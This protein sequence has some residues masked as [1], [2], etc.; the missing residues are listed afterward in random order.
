MSKFLKAFIVGIIIISFFIASIYLIKGDLIFHTDIARDFLLLGEI[1]TKKIVLIG[2][3]A[4]GLNGLF[5]GPLWLYLNYPAYLLG[6]G[7]PVIVGWWWLI[8]T[9]SFLIST[10][11]LVKKLFNSN[12]AYLSLLLISNL[13]IPAAKG[14]FNPYGAMFVFPIFFYFVIQYAKSMSVKYLVILLFLCGLLIQFQLAFGLPI[15][16]L[17]IFYTIYLIFKNKKYLHLLSFLILLIP[18]STFILFDFRHDFSQFHA[19]FDYFTGKIKYEKVSMLTMLSSRLDVIFFSMIELGWLNKLNAL[20]LV[21]VSYNILK[22][23]QKSDSTSKILSIF[24]YYFL[25]FFLLSF[26][27]NG[28]LLYYYY[29]PFIPLCIIIFVSV[30]VKT[31]NNILFGII[32]LIALI[33]FFQASKNMLTDL[34][35]TGNTL[36]SWKFL[37]SVGDRVFEQAPQDEFGLYI[38]TPD[39]LAYQAKYAMSYSQRI[40]KNKHMALNKKKPTTFV[41]EEPPPKE[42]PELDGSWWIVNRIKIT[43]NPDQIVRLN[44]NYLIKKYNLS[45]DEINIPSDPIIDDWITMR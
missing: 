24:T 4:S 45:Q 26:L 33:S 12:T 10:F 35:N 32:L 37:K 30:V 15:L 38:Y 1:D 29:S 20:A 13:V 44:N 14:L 17:T 5:H 43:K 2:P 11:F 42:R 18:L 8:I 6:H 41:I 40:H 16:L 25:G 9:V 23:R 28:W 7:N 22:F 36:S 21:F 3:R 27:H 31:K 39:I 19:V 34:S